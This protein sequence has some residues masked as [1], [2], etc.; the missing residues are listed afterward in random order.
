MNEPEC[1]VLRTTENDLQKMVHL[2]R[3]QHSSM[4][5]QLA[6]A[7]VVCIPAGASLLEIGFMSGGH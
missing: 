4:L 6:A 3:K 7:K 2:Y 1:P 5:K